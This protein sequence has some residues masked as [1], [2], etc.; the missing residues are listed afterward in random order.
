[1]N[2]DDLHK[3][4]ADPHLYF[5][6]IKNANIEGKHKVYNHELP[7]NHKLE[8]KPDENVRTGLF[9]PVPGQ[10]HT[11]TAHP[12]TIKAIRKD[13]FV[14]DLEFEDYSLELE[15]SKCSNAYDLQFYRQCPHC[16]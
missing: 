13:L 7:E 14:S 10:S 11:F 15:C 6:D 9:K 1:M 8:L 12:L 5:N 16:P 2:R 4:L 3:I